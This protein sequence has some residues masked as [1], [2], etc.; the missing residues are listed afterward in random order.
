MFLAFLFLLSY[1]WPLCLSL[2]SFLLKRWEIFKS[3]RSNTLKIMPWYA[4]TYHNMHFWY[5][6][7][8]YKIDLQLTTLLVW[9][10]GV[11]TIKCCTIN[12]AWLHYIS[13]GFIPRN[14]RHT[15]TDKLSIYPN[16]QTCTQTCSIW[17]VH[18]CSYVNRHVLKAIYIPI[19]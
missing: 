5:S 9:W 12:T 14:S 15:H 1:S 13:W 16:T 8:T 17:N 19:F 7:K 10:H 6:P 18:C 2:N 4:D 3:S 11:F